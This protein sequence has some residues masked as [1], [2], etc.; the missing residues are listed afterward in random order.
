MAQLCTK[1]NKIN[2][3]LTPEARISSIETF[4]QSFTD[5]LEYLLGNLTLKNFSSTTVDLLENDLNC[6]L[7]EGSNN[8]AE[9][10]NGL[11]IQWGS[12]LVTPESAGVSVS[13]TIVFSKAFVNPPSI[14]V[15]SYTSVPQNVFCSYTDRNKSEFKIS[16]RRND[17]T[18]TTVSWIAIGI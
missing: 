12:I 1:F 13:K 14:T 6:N 8:T 9:F 10:N 3:G 15:T 5:E 18:P 4:L 17:T 2:K 11:K 16:L 7:T